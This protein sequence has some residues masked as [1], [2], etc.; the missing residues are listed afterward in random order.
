VIF[1][2]FKGTGNMELRLRRD[3]AD[4]R[5]FPA[6]DTVA[7]GTRREEMLLGREELAIIWKLRRVL[8]GQE[9]QSALEMLLN[10]M[11]KTQSNREFLM[12]ISRTTPGQE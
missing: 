7:S 11:R 12:L 6:I 2:E 9:P 10:R 8:S 3:L 5:I 1:E 4:K